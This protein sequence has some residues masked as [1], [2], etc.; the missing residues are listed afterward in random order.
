METNR[1]PSSISPAASRRAPWVDPRIQRVR[2]LINRN[3]HQKLLLRELARSTALSVSR[4]C[5]L[6]KSQTGAAP[7]RY[8]RSLRM[9]KARELLENSSLSVKEVAAAVG[10]DSVSHFVQDFKKAYG[11]TPL[12]Y[13]FQGCQGCPTVEETE[14]SRIGT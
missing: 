6:F 8:L 14:S 13:R 12:Q 9:E 4:L 7:A 3:L 10:R 5:H 11:A 1:D 2:G